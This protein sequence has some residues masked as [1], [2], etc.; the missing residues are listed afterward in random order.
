MPSKDSQ[1]K[2]HSIFAFG[3]QQKNKRF[4]VVEPRNSIDFQ[5][6]TYQVFVNSLKISEVVFSKEQFVD[7]GFS[8]NF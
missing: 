2:N 8:K 4:L 1:G 6:K 5:K 3:L 7:H